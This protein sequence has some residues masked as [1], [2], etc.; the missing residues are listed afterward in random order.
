MHFCGSIFTVTASGVF[1]TRRYYFFVVTMYVLSTLVELKQVCITQ[2]ISYEMNVGRQN[3]FIKA[4]YK[5]IFAISSLPLCF[6]FTGGIG[7]SL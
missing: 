3:I 4:A 1:M 6:R 2:T 5:V 7:C